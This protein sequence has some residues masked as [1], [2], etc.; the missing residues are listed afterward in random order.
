MLEDFKWE[1]DYS[2][3][4]IKLNKLKPIV[5]QYIFGCEFEFYL[6]DNNHY[7]NIKEELF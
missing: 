4:Y 3:R 7:E 6:H 1:A 2:R 5:E